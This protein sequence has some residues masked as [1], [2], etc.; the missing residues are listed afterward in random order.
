MSRLLIVDDEVDYLDELVEAL[1]FA[2]VSAVSVHRAIDALARVT[3]DPQ[4]AVVL[5]D[6]RMPDMDGVALIHALRHAHPCRHLDFVVMTGHA[7]EVDIERARDAGAACCFP[8]PLDFDALC[9]AL[10]S[11]DA[12][13]EDV[14]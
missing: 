12:A 8:K 5:T 11:L 3:A 4:I 2:G 14:S 9:A 1:G 13:S 6:I 7:A 10:V